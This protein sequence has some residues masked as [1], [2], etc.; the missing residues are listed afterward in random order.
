[1]ISSQGSAMAMPPAPLRTVRRSTRNLGGSLEVTDIRTSWLVERAGEKR[2]GLRQRDQQLTHAAVA[3]SEVLHQ[4]LAR[5]RV[6]GRLAAPV[7]ERHPF[8]DVAALGIRA[9]REPYAELDRAVERSLRVRH[10]ELAGRVDGL[11]VLGVAP[12]ADGVVVLE[13][14]AQPV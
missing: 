4:Q 10:H 12:A 7:G 9:A 5:A 1:M 11:A 8:A 2:I 13:R 6:F 3:A 14:E